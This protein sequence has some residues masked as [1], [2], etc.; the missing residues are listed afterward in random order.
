MQK[1]SL[2]TGTKL[3]DIFLVVSAIAI[4]MAIHLS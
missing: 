2:P 1:P 4:M 3:F